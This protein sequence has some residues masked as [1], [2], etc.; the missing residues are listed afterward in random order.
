M[1]Y[2]RYLN[3][4]VMNLEI[5]FYVEFV[6]DVKMRVWVFIVGVLVC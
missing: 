5:I 2:C 6:E 3:T 4:L 1:I